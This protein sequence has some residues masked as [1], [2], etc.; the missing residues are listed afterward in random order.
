MENKIDHL[1]TLNPFPT[2]QPFPTIIPAPPANIYLPITIIYI[3]LYSLVFIYVYFQLVLIW[4]FKHKRFSYQTSFLFISLLWASLRILLFSFYFQNAKDANMLF[5]V[6]YF[7]LY[8]LPVILQF[9]TLCLLV[10]Y[11]GQVYFK[12]ATR[13]RVKKNRF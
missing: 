8:C 2:W 10:L 1:S 7:L 4:Y 3:I 12:I 9:I 13:N 5:F 6:F 11:Y